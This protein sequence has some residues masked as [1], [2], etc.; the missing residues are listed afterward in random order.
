MGD[1]ETTAS[2]V[3]HRPEN[4]ALGAVLTT[5]AFFCVA[6]VGTLAKVCGQFTSTGVLLVFQNLICFV[7]VTKSGSSLANRTI[8]L[9]TVSRS[10]SSP[11]AR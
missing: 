9:T 5:T 6:L 8:G 4:L 2:G 7:F 3:G 11:A 1:A 10:S